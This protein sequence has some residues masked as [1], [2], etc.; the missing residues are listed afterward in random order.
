LLLGFGGRDVA[1]KHLGAI[2]SE[3]KALAKVIPGLDVRA[4]SNQVESPDDSEN[5]AEQGDRA[6]DPM[7][8]DRKPL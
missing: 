3:K 1:D 8:S 4:F 5:A 6:V 2:H 7:Q